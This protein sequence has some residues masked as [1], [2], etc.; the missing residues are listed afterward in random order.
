MFNIGDQSKQAIS[1]KFRIHGLVSHVTINRPLQSENY[2]AIDKNSCRMACN[3]SISSGNRVHKPKHNNY[4]ELITSFHK[5]LKIDNT[6]ETNSEVDSN[7]TS[8]AL[9]LYKV[10]PS[11]SDMKKS[12]SEIMKSFRKPLIRA[13]THTILLPKTSIESIFQLEF[14]EHS[15]KTDE[16]VN[17][18]ELD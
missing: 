11:S 10:P 1:Y 6:E 12:S 13:K 8:T 18:M 14:D 16:S 17:E 3:R 4:D 5:K 9:I 15:K 7:C 2:Q